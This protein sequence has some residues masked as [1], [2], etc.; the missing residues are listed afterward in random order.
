MSA[1]SK[2]SPKAF[3]G[4]MIPN[5]KILSSSIDAI[6]DRLNSLSTSDSTISVTTLTTTTLNTVDK[7]TT[8]TADGAISVPTANTTYYI[9]KAGVAAMTIVDPTAT[10]HDGL[11]LTF[12]A[13]TANA[14]TLSNA[15]GS[16]FNDGGAASD[17]GTY[18]G[19]KGDNIIITAYQGKWYVKSK[20]N[21]TLA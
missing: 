5:V 8:V 16:G 10:T 11:T 18:G 12:V 13:T 6:I 20:V 7:F 15:A 2:L 9:T 17:I 3:L 21:V 19:A 1:I 14:H 4:A